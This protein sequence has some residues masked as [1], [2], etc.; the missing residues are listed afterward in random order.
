MTFDR[1]N[2]AGY[3]VNLMARLFARH[4]EAGIRPLGIGTGVF[5]A[6]LMLWDKDGVTQRDLVDALEIEQPTMA[7]TLSRME[8]DG[9][10]PRRRD[11]TDGRVQRIWLTD[12][13]RAL[14]TKATGAANAVNAKALAGLSPA[15]QKQFMDLMRK[16]T[17]ALERE[18]R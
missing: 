4:L 8:R 16:V 1:E 14:E 18:Y 17:A 3:V 11:E 13:A 15:E 6:L 7:N 5:P 2:S 12:K 9:L 10:I